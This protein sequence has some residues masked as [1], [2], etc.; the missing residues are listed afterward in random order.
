MC[1][2][3]DREPSVCA[4]RPRVFAVKSHIYAPE[5]LESAD[6][7]PTLASD[8]YAYGLLL[9]C[10]FSGR[11]RAWADEHGYPPSEAQWTEVITRI[12]NLRDRPDLGALRPD[13][14]PDV[15]DLMQ[16]CW[17]QVC[18]LRGRTDT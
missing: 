8:M 2:G 5:L 16:H 17:A 18:L 11:S 10:L 7:S 9:W 1:G 14:P 4:A 12:V 3:R 6:R 15:K 13:T